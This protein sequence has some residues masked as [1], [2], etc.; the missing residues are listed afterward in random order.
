MPKTMAIKWLNCVKMT[1]RHHNFQSL[2]TSLQIGPFI[3][4]I[5][6]NLVREC[7]FVKDVFELHT[8]NNTTHI[9]SLKQANGDVLELLIG[10]EE[11]NN[12][13]KNIVGP[14]GH[15]QIESAGGC[16]AFNQC[17]LHIF[18]HGCVH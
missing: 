16:R 14:F 3:L 9:I 18:G 13:R 12:H 7:K 1:T 10:E 2:N 15:P 5:D 17:K 11:I 8:H 6:H 4:N